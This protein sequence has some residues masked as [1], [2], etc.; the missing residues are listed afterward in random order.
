V[1]KN[2]L[3][4]PEVI[5]L[6]QDALGL[7]GVPVSA[8]GQTVWAKPLNESGARGVVLL[9]AGITA[10]DIMFTLPQ[11]GLRGGSAVARDLVQHMDLPAFQDTFTA[12]GV[13]PHATV[14]LRVKGTEPPRPT[15]TAYLSDLTPIYA[16]DGLALPK[17]DKSTNAT[18]L[19]IGGASFARGLGVAAPSQ[20]I[21]RLAKKCTTFTAMVGVDDSTH[22]QGSVVFQVWAD[23][24][25]ADGGSFTFTKLYESNKVVGGAPPV[26]VQVPLDNKRRL[27]LLVTNAL[28]GSAQ[29][30]ADW[31]AAQVTCAP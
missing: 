6:N 19:S 5:A 30:R 4:N 26:S 22:G 1:I 25:E 18:S 16:A 21:Y 17:K 10:A 11:I 29:D 12:S 2:I 3:T 31:A 27:K 14:T 9:N 23:E 28:D 7:Q 15:G 24:S 20:I 8:D 13:A